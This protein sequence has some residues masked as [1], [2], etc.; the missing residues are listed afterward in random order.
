MSTGEKVM[1]G[2]LLNGVLF[3]IKGLFFTI[4]CMQAGA[5]ISHLKEKTWIYAHHGL[6]TSGL[7]T[8]GDAA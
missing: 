3:C 8:K 6:N 2:L 4:G 1:L 5:L 7:P